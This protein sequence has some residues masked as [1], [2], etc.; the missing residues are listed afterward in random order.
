MTLFGVGARRDD[1]V[2]PDPVWLGKVYEPLRCSTCGR[3]WPPHR[4]KSFVVDLIDTPAIHGQ[5]LGAPWKLSVILLGISVF[6]VLK[7]YLVG[8]AQGAVRING[9]VTDRYITLNPADECRINLHN[10]A[11]SPPSL[12][13]GCPMC[14]RRMS[15]TM[16]QAYYNPTDVQLERAYVDSGGGLLLTDALVTAVQSVTTEPLNI[17]PILPGPPPYWKDGPWPPP[18]PDTVK[19]P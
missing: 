11:F 16:G 2:T 18:D 6:R 7:S 13:R 1:G 3:L 12:I 14:G 15:G 5:F 8:F 19:T 17:T 4:G 9:V 10:D